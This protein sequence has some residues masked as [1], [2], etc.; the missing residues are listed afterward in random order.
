M[1]GASI[2]GTPCELPDGCSIL[3]ALRAVGLDLP[4][5]CHDDHLAPTG[6]CRLC[7]AHV[8]GLARPVPACATPLVN[9]MTVATD[10]PDLRENRRALL[11]MLVRRYPADAIRQ[12]PDE[13]FQ[14]APTP[15]PPC[16]RPST[17][18]RPF[19]SNARRTRYVVSGFSRT[20]GHDVPLFSRA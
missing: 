3:D 4:A 7:L 15:T 6:A 10:T 12:S 9:G 20:N 11:E 14:Q 16:R 8:D 2:N 1:I 17:K 19:D 5:M 18:S 13:P